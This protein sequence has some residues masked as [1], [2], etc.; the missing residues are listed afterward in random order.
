LTSAAHFDKLTYCGVSIG[1]QEES[2]QTSRRQAA[3]TE[4]PVSRRN[5]IKYGILTAAAVV[6]PL[7]VL[8]A[9]APSRQSFRELMF[10]N[11]H[12]HEHLSVC[13][14]RNGQYDPSALRK[15]NYI[16]RDHRS[17]EIKPI[18]ARLLDLLHTLSGRLGAESPYHIISGYRSPAT[19]TRLRRNSKGVASRSLHMK[20]KAID[21]RVP[22]VSLS[23][24][25][26]AAVKMGRGGV[27]Y[28]PKSDFVHVD[29]G[30]VRYW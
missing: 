3:R 4:S 30:R 28:Y 18:D 10:Y 12:T 1:L 8:S 22:G 19:N 6:A 9:P 21:I 17:G 25:R 7:P 5:F 26:N 11:L 14:C 27:G 15:I 16:L 24:L 13:Y 2:L 23:A 20:G 29:T